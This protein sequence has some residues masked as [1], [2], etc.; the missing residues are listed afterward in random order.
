[1]VIKSIK[2]Q[3]T[4]VYHTLINESSVPI[5]N[6]IIFKEIPLLTFENI[7]HKNAPVCFVV[8]N[9]VPSLACKGIH[10]LLEV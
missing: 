2:A 4:H 7:G 8:L 5:F 10:D 6:Y 3:L 1:M 9:L